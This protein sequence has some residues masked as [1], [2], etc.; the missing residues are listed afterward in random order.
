MFGMPIRTT[1]NSSKLF[2]AG[3]LMKLNWL[4]N[5]IKLDENSSNFDEI[6]SNLIKF[7]QICQNVTKSWN[8]IYTFWGFWIYYSRNLVI[9]GQ[10]YIIIRRFLFCICNI[11]SLCTGY[12]GKALYK[13][14]KNSFSL[15]FNCVL[16][17]V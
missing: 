1:K 5:V 14:Y 2:S 7:R 9:T 13:S 16:V 12:H 15:F 17:R 3:P 11:V 4:W 10:G 6:S 8:Q